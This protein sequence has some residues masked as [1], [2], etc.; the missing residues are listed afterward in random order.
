MPQQKAARAGTQ[1]AFA[2][3]IG[4]VGYG[5]CHFIGDARHARSKIINKLREAKK[6]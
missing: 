6:H 3:G 1:A 4:A 2:S 5:Q